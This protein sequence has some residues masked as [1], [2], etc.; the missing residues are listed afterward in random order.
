MGLLSGY[1]LNV[2]KM[3]KGLAKTRGLT[4]QA[5]QSPC[6]EV[7]HTACDE[8]LDTVADDL[9]IGLPPSLL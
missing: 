7:L 5:S 1:F 3:E 4:A 2:S 8:A 9:S 6:L